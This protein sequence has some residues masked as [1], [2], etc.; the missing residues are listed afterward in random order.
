MAE[1]TITPV[2]TTSALESLATH[3]ADAVARRASSS[4]LARVAIA[5]GS[6][7]EVM[8]RV[9]ART[10]PDL[11]RRVALTL[12]DER[13]VP[14]SSP[15]STWGRARSRAGADQAGAVLPMVVDGEDAKTACGRFLD[16]FRQHFQG[17]LDVAV[18]GMG[19]DGHVASLFPGHRLLD[20][21]GLVGWLDDAPKPP[22]TRVTM[23]FDALNQPQT[24]R[25]LY[26]VGPAKRPALERLLRRDPTLPASRLADFTLVTDQPIGELQP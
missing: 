20:Q 9:V 17:G 19:E 7:L 11:W 4:G 14:W 12:V 2:V 3:L 1:A 22:P 25:F 24:M 5:G 10:S 23:L 26:A 18:L 13:V 15:D 21:T 6:V 8:E 16:G